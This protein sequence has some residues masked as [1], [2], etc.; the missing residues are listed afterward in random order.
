MVGKYLTN[1]KYMENNI[2]EGIKYLEKAA[3][4][5]WSDAILDLALIYTKGSLVEEDLLL[6]AEWIKKSAATGNIINQLYLAEL[7]SNGKLVDGEHFVE[8]LSW[9]LVSKENGNDEAFK[10]IDKLKDVMYPPLVKLSKELSEQCLK[11]NYKNCQV[12]L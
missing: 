6:A 8:A 3:N 2:E 5:G 9:A 12:G 7:L 10:T 4:Q 1:A 11:S